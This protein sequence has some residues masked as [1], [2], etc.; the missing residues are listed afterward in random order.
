MEFYIFY[1]TVDCGFTGHEYVQMVKSCSKD[2]AL[3]E[4]KL[5]Y[6]NYILQSRCL[7]EVE[8]Q[9]ILKSK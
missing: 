2:R 6:G 4:F 1:R 3:F 5:K 9:S 8:Y 7:N